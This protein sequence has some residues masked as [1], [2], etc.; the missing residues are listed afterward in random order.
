M[1]FCDLLTSSE[2]EY[3]K[4]L[5][6]HLERRQEQSEVLQK[7]LIS[8][9]GDMDA[10]NSELR[11]REHQIKELEAL[12]DKLYSGESKTLADLEKILKDL[13]TTVDMLQVQEEGLMKLDPESR[14]DALE[15]VRKRLM[16]RQA[17]LVKIQARIKALAPKA[18]PK[19]PKAVP[20]VPQ[21]SKSTEAVEIEVV[22]IDN[23]ECLSVPTHRSV[24]EMRGIYALEKVV[25]QK[26][27]FRER[28]NG[29]MDGL[30]SALVDSDECRVRR[31]EGWDNKV[32]YRLSYQS[33]RGPMKTV[34]VNQED[35]QKISQRLQA[36]NYEISPSLDSPVMTIR[37]LRAAN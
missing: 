8:C 2:Q 3:I 18:V 24:L 23:L 4:S 15:S 30:Y 27:K 16:T 34:K 21:E 22:N 29:F 25:R 7:K 10:N 6:R 19:V 17:D 1:T 5:E 26:R 12:I 20:K 36:D 11:V 14:K 13:T 33:I 31:R 32:T 28:T 9:T 35:W 37:L